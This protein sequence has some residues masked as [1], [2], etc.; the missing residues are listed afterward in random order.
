MIPSEKIQRLT[1]STFQ[2]PFRLVDEI[3]QGMDQRN[4]RRVFEQVVHCSEADGQ[5][6]YFMVSP[7]LLP[8]RPHRDSFAYFLSHVCTCN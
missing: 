7:K 3:N 6:Q 1:V 2:C 5:S 4:E 8:G